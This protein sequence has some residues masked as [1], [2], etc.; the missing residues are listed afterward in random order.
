M[1]ARDTTL[2]NRI[3]VIVQDET[4]CI[5][6]KLVTNLVIIRS[7]HTHIRV[8]LII[9]SKSVTTR[10]SL[11][12]KMQQELI[13]LHQFHIRSRPIISMIPTLLILTVKPM[14]T[15]YQKRKAIV[16][17]IISNLNRYRLMYPISIKRSSRNQQLQKKLFLQKPHQRITLYVQLRIFLK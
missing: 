9:R 16:K 4:R 10:S 2:E 5:Q 6:S 14:M 1:V 8:I 3:N 15:K 17:D 12:I 7:I 11:V 13:P